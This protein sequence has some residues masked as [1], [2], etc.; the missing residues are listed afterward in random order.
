MVLEVAASEVAAASEEAA[1]REVLEA[2]VQQVTPVGAYR[3]EVLRVR[4]VDLD[5]T[6]GAGP[7][8]PF[9]EVLKDASEEGLVATTSEAVA[10]ASK[11]LEVACQGQEAWHPMSQLG[12]TFKVRVA[13]AAKVVY[14]LAW[15]LSRLLG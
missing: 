9:G 14:E 10:S 8:E 5:A 12:P 1:S 11:V 6:S 13:M 4:E 3:E 7:E 2:A 15:T